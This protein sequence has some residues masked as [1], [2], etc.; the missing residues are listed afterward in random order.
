MNISKEQ[1]GELE[2]T[3]QISIENE[4]YQKDVN[5][6]LK[7][8]QRK[9]NMPGFRP[10]K[11][12]M[13]MI[14]KMYGKSVMA[15]KVNRLISDTLNNYIIENKLP[16]LGY[17]LANMEKTGTIDFDESDTFEFFFDI[18]LAPD[19]ELEPEKVE[20]PAYIKAIATADKVDEAIQ[21]ILKNAAKMVDVEVVESND[22][23][24]LKLVQ[25][26][27]N[28]EELEDGYEKTI[29]LELDVIENE[30]E[31]AIFVGKE[32]GAEFVYNFSRAISDEEKRLDILQL[33]A[34]NSAL[35]TSD[36]NVIIDGIKRRKEAELNE[37]LFNE[38]Y[39][40]KE[41][42]SEEEFR[43]Q[44]KEDIEKQYAN[45]CDRYFLNKAMDAMIEHHQFDMPEAFIKRWLH[46]NSEGKLTEDE[47]EQDFEN[48][49]KSMRWQLIS[50]KL[51]GTNE[52]LKVQSEEV[53]DVV[54][55]HFMG[56]MQMPEEM[57]DEMK[58]RMDGIVDTI[59]Q[60]KEEAGKIKD[61]LAEQKL[62]RFFKEKLAPEV[63]E[64]NY[65]DFVN[66]VTGKND[67]NE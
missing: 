14:K 43:V 66:L 52:E 10:G 49:L 41:I 51:E 50:G 55:R 6:E 42:K 47:I 37:E 53:R 3:I 32:L 57:A 8:Y 30:S 13:G 28:G 34:E 65:D 26:N 7:Q 31:K 38:M 24:E 15:E 45:D 36:F 29:Q 67:E 48:Y 23:L 62:A 11:V 60:N 35:S 39:P 33:D 5:D 54:R 12:P 58:E 27:E 40:D 4:D 1:T 59:L 2:A 17:P 19:F 56:S 9:A 44:I 63:Q 25:A 16:V 64:M 22:T 21:N 46:D 20:K 18:G 61:Q